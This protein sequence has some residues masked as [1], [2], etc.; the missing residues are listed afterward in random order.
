[1]PGQ[2]VFR[3]GHRFPGGN[4]KSAAA[5]VRARLSCRREVGASC[6]AQPLA[7]GFWRLVRRL[8]PGYERAN[9]WLDS[10]DTDLHRYGL[11]ARRRERAIA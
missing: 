10:R 8:H 7:P 5:G 6:R 1:M 3:I 2:R 9:A 4:F 11:P